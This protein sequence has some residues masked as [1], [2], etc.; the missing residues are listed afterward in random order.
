MPKPPLQAALQEGD[1]VLGFAVRRVTPL[2]NLRSTAYE[3]EHLK[4]RARLLHV[5]ND[6]A[7]NL[8]CIAFRTPPADDTG[9]PHI[10]EHSV[11]AG[12]R[13]F[14]VK[15]PFVEMVKMSMATF[16]NAMTYS[17]KT[18]YPVSSNVRQ[19]F[20]NLAEVYCD[21]VFH[22]R[23]TE[24]TFKQEGHHLEFEKKNGSAGNLIVK[25][26]VYNE[27][28]G[29]YSSADELVDR[30]SSQA[31]FP[32]TPYGKDSGGNPEQIPDLTY[33]QFKN[34][35]QKL[36]HPSNAFIFLYGD[37]LTRDLLAFLRKK[38][39]AFS[40]RKIDTAI[41]RQKRWKQPRAL[42]ERYP[43]GKEEETKTK[44]YLTLNWIVGDGTEPLDVLAI[45]V[46]DSVL[47]GHE[48]A[49]LRKA[50][51]DS[52]LGED[53]TDSGFSAGRLEVTF[54]VGLKGSEA[55]RLDALRKLVFATL[56]RIAAEGVPKEK[57]DAAFHQIAYRY[58]EIQSMFPLWQMD[59]AFY[60]WIYGADPLAF[61]RADELLAE[62][63]RRFEGDP[64]LLGRLIRE[65][66]IENPHRVDV[67][68]IP[69]REMQERKEAAFAK[70]MKKLKAGLRPA[71]LS[72][73]AK[74]AAE[75]ERLQS[76][77]NSV[78]ALATLPQLKVR[79]LPRKPKHIPTT[80]E[81]LEGGVEL[82]RNEVF[83]NGVNYLNLDFNLEGLPAGLYPY[84]TLYS[85]AVQK[86]GAAGL[87]Y[88]QMAE[89][90]TA[91]TGGVR[92]W[93]YSNAH[94]VDTGRCM[95][96][97]RFS[98]KALDEKI[99]P[100]LGV[101]RDLLFELNPRNRA[102]LQEVLVQAKAAYRSA[103]VSNGLDM[104]IRH[105]ARGLNRENQILEIL[106]GLPQTRMG[107]QLADQFE[108]RAEEVMAKFEAI[109]HFLLNRSRLVASFTGSNQ[110]HEKVR[111]ALVKWA[112]AMRAEP[113]QD[114][115]LDFVAQ[116]VPR[117]EGLAAPM[118]V[119]FC[120]QVIPAPHVAHP[121]GPL[122]HVASRL[123][124][125]GY[126]WEEVR[127]KGGAYGGGCGY[128]GLEKLWHWFSYR[129]PWVHK[130]LDTFQ[131]LL[132][133]VQKAKWSQTDIGRAIIGTAKGGERPI[134][135]S[136]ATGTALWRHING[137]TPELR[138]QRHAGILRAT[139]KEVRR[140]VLELLEKNT[141]N[142]SL[143][144]VSSREKLE[145]ANRERPAAELSIE[146]IMK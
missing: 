24:H 16:I 137:D 13:R 10:L 132:G 26:I 21:A 131:G 64:G 38:L 102:R 146:E 66:L 143:C 5:H 74:A 39:D 138:E 73:I 67:T 68:V 139:A 33:R 144:V 112:G 2:K 125:L 56:S 70:K 53:L 28:K 106:G 17:D 23:L 78:K 113:I 47:L 43:V 25:G 142:V 123:L 35:H 32:G 90:I 69:D 8:F 58:L 105:A 7:E 1:R 145:A 101:L 126:M 50:L 99:E 97:A 127:I 9:L 49:P 118:E 94:T 30:I 61:L 108:E 19:D 44:T 96:R 92:F 98:L 136:E 80:V 88:V 57:V 63:R 116:A 40:H 119:A 93:P 133:H 54:H 3:L 85:H 117:R 89:R 104:A 55:A 11:L 130:T 12:S 124:S 128:S 121:D 83:S 87:D 52:K 134:R 18:V 135:P 77:P 59:R 76:K 48:G 72:R 65:R 84:L 100:A 37:I 6:D 129:D 36:Y 31:L 60:T 45:S 42:V 120:A 115:P 140:A 15:D 4:T 22:P 79:D 34:F 110:A 109:R 29:A 122:L 107:E 103:L 20:F 81:R 51:I 91:L 41:P 27:M 114:V 62:L 14:P 82:L 46:L 141:S 75:L 71:A 86:M 111:A 95:R